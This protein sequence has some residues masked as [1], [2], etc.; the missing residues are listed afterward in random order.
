MRSLLPFVV[1]AACGGDDGPFIVVTIETRPAVHDIRALS[2]TLANEGTSREDTFEVGTEDFPATF[3]ISAPGRVGQ[4]GISVAARD[5]DG[6]LVGRGDVDTTLDVLEATVLL[7]SADFVVNTEFADD[8]FPS[9]DFESN[10]FQ[11]AAG[12]D[13]TWTAV[14]RDACIPSCN[15]FAR[16]FDPT[17]APVETAVAAGTNGFFLSSDLTTGSTT[18]A[19]ATSG[20]TTVAVWDFSEPSPSTVDGIACRALDAAGN[21]AGPQVPVSVETLPDVV[22]VAPLPGNA[23]ALQWNGFNAANIIKGATVNAQCQPSNVVQ[24]STN[25]GTSGAS[26][27]SV[28]TNGD[29]ILYAWI[30]DTEV[31]GRVATAS[32]FAFLN[33]AD[34]PLVLKTATEHIEHVRVAPLG[35]GFAVV[36]RWAVDGATTG[37]GRLELYRTN[38]GGQ[39]MGGPT[40]IST[41]SG[42]DFES[43]KSFGVAERREDGALLV[44]W[45][46]CN[47]NGD[48]S[49]CGVFGRVVRPSGVPVGDEFLLAT[50]T[51][52][53]QTNPA[54]VAVPGAFAVM[55][56]DTSQQDPDK[57]GTAARARIIYPAFDDAKLVL[58]APCTSAGE[59]N[60]GLACASSSEGGQR[61]FATC[62]AEGV[63]P[64]CPGGGTCTTIVGGSA[65]LF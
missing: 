60:A 62:N 23:F 19:V 45:H 40:L 10:G 54:A 25:A 6:I 4:L 31:R 64:R 46:S 18:P 63:E 5:Q 35:A 12:P 65:C 2:V 58:G 33:G 13:G 29:R 48:D 24:V 11:L 55:W 57:S 22:S 52:L 21:F 53:D 41:R 8:Q 38:N 51:Q 20:A 16:R 1:L 3:S 44:V 50:T 32:P 7:D 49:G 37:P 42:T 14:Y 34:I 28:A 61:C 15:M 26:R 39:L 9:N 59:C 43:R 47:D 30:L 17:G 27:G 36:V 56:S